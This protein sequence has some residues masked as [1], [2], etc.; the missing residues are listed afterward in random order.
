MSLF[1]WCGLYDETIKDFYLIIFFLSGINTKTSRG[2]LVRLI[3]G[4]EGPL[5]K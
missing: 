3:G 5:Y 4:L 2:N 1:S